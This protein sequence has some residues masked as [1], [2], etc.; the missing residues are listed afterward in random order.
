MSRSPPVTSFGI[1]WKRDTEWS[2][3]KLYGEHLP[4]PINKKKPGVVNFAGQD[5][6]YLLHHDREIVYVGQTVGE[7][8][9]LAERLRAH[10]RSPTLRSRWNR[11][12][13]FGFREVVHDG[14]G[15]R[16]KNA[17]LPSTFSIRDLMAVV[18]AILI[19]AVEPRNNR[20]GGKGFKDLAY[21]PVSFAEAEKM[22]AKGVR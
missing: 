19:E 22:M 20:Q 2:P 17:H 9:G 18:E 10:T 12:S 16:L 1:Y 11:F 5:A 8:A 21:G 7:T 14:S 3:T 15:G 4:D 6:V 13:W